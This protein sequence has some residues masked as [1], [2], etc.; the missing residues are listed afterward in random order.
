MIS[1]PLTPPADANKVKDIFGDDLGDKYNEDWV[2]YKFDAKT[3]QYGTPLEITDKLETGKG[4]WIIQISGESKSLDMPANS[5]YTKPN[6]FDIELES[7]KEVNKYQWNLVGLPF[8]TNIK[9]NDLTLSPGVHKKLWR[10]KY[11]EGTGGYETIEGE[12]E[13]TPWDAFWTATKDTQDSKIIVKTFGTE[14]SHRDKKVVTWKSNDESTVF[15]RRNGVGRSPVVFFAPGWGKI[16]EAQCETEKY[17]P[18]WKFITSHGYAVICN[19]KPNQTT[20]SSKMI[21]GFKKAAVD[22]NVAPYINL[23]KIGVMGHS[24]GGGHSF[25]ILKYLGSSEK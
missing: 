23:K 13:L 11:A 14:G 6:P 15:H 9:F 18:L 1:L 2:L 19:N 7:T 12:N 16:D 3:N 24:S 10:Y 4:Y 5:Y 17:A 25:K 21:E 22:E 8:N 20:D